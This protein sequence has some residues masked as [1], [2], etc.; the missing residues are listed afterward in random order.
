VKNR[1]KKVPLV[2]N[3]NILDGWPSHHFVQLD[4]NFMFETGNMHFLIVQALVNKTI[5]VTTFD[6]CNIAE[7]L[8]ILNIMMAFNVK[9]QVLLY[10]K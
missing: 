2:S 7:N 1:L 8:R 6:F 5:C 3:L 9:S 4:D 10:Q